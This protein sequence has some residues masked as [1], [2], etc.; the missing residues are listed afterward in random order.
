MG[1]RIMLKGKERLLK[2]ILLTGY[3]TV[4]WYHASII[5]D[6]TRVPAYTRKHPVFLRTVAGGVRDKDDRYRGQLQDPQREQ[7]QSRTGVNMGNAP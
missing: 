5:Q 6:G 4:L 7:R 3:K 2:K 1:K